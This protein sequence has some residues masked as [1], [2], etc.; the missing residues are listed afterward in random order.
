MSQTY[1]EWAR[2]NFSHNNLSLKEHN[3]IVQSAM[4]YLEK[5]NTKFDLIFLDP[6]TF[7]NSKKLV[8]DFE[9]EKDHVNLIKQCL[10]IL[11]NDGVLYFSNNK[12]KFKLDPIVH[13]L[14]RVED[15]S[16]KTI[17]QDFRDPKIHHCYRITHVS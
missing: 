16:L 9:V 4:E 3:F 2:R 6:P 5:A 10:K 12:R 13:T 1:Q 7:S 17:P 15:I 11:N 8:E 14:A